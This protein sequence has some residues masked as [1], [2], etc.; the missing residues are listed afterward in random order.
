[1]YEFISPSEFLNFTM[2]DDPIIYSSQRQIPPPAKFD[3]DKDK[4]DTNEQEQTAEGGDNKRKDQ[5]PL[6]ERGQ[7]SKYRGYGI[8]LL[9]TG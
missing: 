5:M 8:T 6:K 1:M 2:S 3:E 4:D 9:L 7:R